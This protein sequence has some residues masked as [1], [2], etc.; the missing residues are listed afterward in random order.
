MSEEIGIYQLGELKF[1]FINKKI[2]YRGKEITAGGVTRPITPPI[3]SEEIEDGAIITSKIAD[4]AVTRAK[5]EYP[6]E[7]VSFA[8]LLAI[9]KAKLQSFWSSY[10]GETYPDMMIPTVDVFTDKGVE[11]FISDHS[12]WIFVRAQDDYDMYIYEAMSGNST[13]DILFRVLSG[14]TSTMLWYEA[15]D[16]TAGH[17]FL[18]KITVAGSTFTIYKHD[19][20]TAKATVTDTTYASGMFG[21]GLARQ[22]SGGG[23]GMMAPLVAWLRAPSSRTR[24]AIDL[25]AKSKPDR[26]IFIVEMEVE[27]SGKL[28][29]SIRPAFLKDIDKE[30]NIDRLAVT[31][32]AFDYKGEPTMICVITGDNPYKSGAILRQVEYARKKGLLALRAPRD[33]KEAILQ[34]ENIRK[35]RPKMLA[36]KDNYA[37]QVLGDERLEPFAVADFY[38]GELLEHQAHKDQIKRV[39]AWEFERTLNRWLNRLERVDVLHHEK[40][41]HIRKLKEVLKR[42]W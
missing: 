32:G 23:F 14:G 36:G 16:I 6:T 18:A 8:Y 38:Y 34:Y 21:I 26:G 5:L 3:T 41:K 10:Y 4:R 24:Y 12:Q 31:W 2:T 15:V 40:D 39:P 33:Y 17:G 9:D 29:D 13:Q 42:G 20:T 1:D 27:G 19:L 22:A 28:D 11:T 7:D 30:L 35:H 37:Y 25:N